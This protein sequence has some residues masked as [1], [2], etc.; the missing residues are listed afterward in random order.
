MRN[1]L[2]FINR[3]S[4]FLLFLLFESIALSILVINNTYQRSITISSANELVGDAYYR[5]NS[6]EDYLSLKSTNDS[7]SSE[8]AALRNQLQTSFL[9]TRLDTHRVYSPIN[10]QRYLYLS[11]QVINNSIHQK[12]NY[13]TVNKG[14][15][16]GI[17]KGMG[18][19]SP[20]GVVGIVVNV[21][22]RF[23]IVQSLLHKDTRISA[24]IERN[25]SFGSLIWG[26][27]IDS[28]KAVLKD[29]PS[30]VKIKTG[31]K[32][33]TS[34]FSLFPSGIPIGK[35][36]RFGVKGGGSFLDIDVFLATN[37]GTLEYVY[38]VT[39]KMKKEQESLESNLK[40]D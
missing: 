15:V 21:S 14:F 23:S 11:A 24:M 6:V 34:G 10:E 27:Q 39:D 31:D 1:L 7:L 37:F 19:I 17:K 30:H 4:A 36:T 2:I 35:I 13:I 28:R 8:N 40:N 25:K 12:N 32:I 22:P 20:S 3:Y 18:V 33:V 5:L 16:D 26:D 9:N 38:I 29:I